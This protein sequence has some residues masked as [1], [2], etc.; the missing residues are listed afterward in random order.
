MRSDGTSSTPAGEK[1]IIFWEG[2]SSLLKQSGIHVDW[3]YRGG[4]HEVM[5]ERTSV[6]GIMYS[7]RITNNDAYA[8]VYIEC[9][10][11]QLSKQRYD[12]LEGLRKQIEC[13]FGESLLWERMPDKKASWIGKKFQLGLVHT[14][15]R[16]KL[17][18]QMA[19]A[20]IRLK[21]SFLGPIAAI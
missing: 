2:L 10:S 5:Y 8:R 9:S 3:K 7:F 17:Y 12:H 13:D 4:N 6:S 21:K 1:N 18:S 19:D 16:D 11:Q 14:N 20:M 15:D